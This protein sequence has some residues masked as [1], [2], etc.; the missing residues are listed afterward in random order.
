MTIDVLDT[1]ANVQEG[2]RR[3]HAADSA[4]HAA[5]GIS[6]NTGLHT[7]SGDDIRLGSR[8][9]RSRVKSSAGVPRHDT[10]DSAPGDHGTV[11]NS[12]FEEGVVL[13]CVP[14]VDVYVG[15]GQNGGCIVDG[16]TAQTLLPSSINKRGVP[17][18][19]GGHHQAAGG[20]ACCGASVG[21]GTSSVVAGISQNDDNTAALRDNGGGGRTMCGD[22]DNGNNDADS[23]GGHCVP[24]AQAR[25]NG[26]TETPSTS[27][28]GH[29]DQNNA[30]PTAVTGSATSA[31]P[32]SRTP[33]HPRQRLSSFC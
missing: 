7:T 24:S 28:A 11:T 2:K 13:I 23:R 9:L 17:G 26:V 3:Q 30:S 16:A 8:T 20:D 6:L 33:S 27:N 22:E 4:S 32:R 14:Y 29:A 19:E 31:S 25:P 1:F 15:G 12:S 10:A 5:D 18:A 21:D